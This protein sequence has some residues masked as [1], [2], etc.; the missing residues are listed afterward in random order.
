MPALLTKRTDNFQQRSLFDQD[1]PESEQLPRRFRIEFSEIL[2]QRGPTV[3]L[4]KDGQQVGDPLTDHAFV[5]DG[6]R[7]HDVFHFANAAILG[8]S[9]MTRSLFGCKRKSNQQIATVED[10]GRAKVLEEVVCALI[11]DY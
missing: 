9:P 7:Y 4:H 5:D 3:V 10:G 1:Y 8:W 6:Y 2:G 11:Y